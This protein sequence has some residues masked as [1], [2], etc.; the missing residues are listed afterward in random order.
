MIKKATTVFIILFICCSP[1]SDLPNISFKV[2]NLKTFSKIY[3][4]IKY[5][6][7]SDEAFALDWD[8]FSIYAANKILKCETNEAFINTIDSLF[9]PI[10]PSIRFANSNGDS[11]KIENSNNSDVLGEQFWFHKGVGYGMTMENDRYYS[12]R[13]IATPE[14]DSISYR[15]KYGKTANVSIY[16]GQYVAIPLVVYVIKA[17]TIPKSNKKELNYLL[18]NLH[19]YKIDE[20]SLS[21]RLG[22]II[23]TYN[24][25]QHFFPYFD[26]LRLDWENELENALIR[27][28]KDSS[29]K[30][31]L[32]TLRKF[33]SPL[34]DGHITIDAKGVKEGVYTPP[35]FWEWIGDKLIISDVWK[36]DLNLERGDEIIKING[37]SSKEYFDE[38]NSMI[39]AGTLGWLRNISEELSLSGEKG[40]KITIETNS[41]LIEVTRDQEPY[42]HSK[43][44]TPYEKID[45]RIEYINLSVLDMA[46][47]NYLLPELEKSTGL[48]ID[49]R[50]YPN[51]NGQLIGHLMKT[52]DTTKAWMY[53]PEIVYPD[54]QEPKSYSTSNG[55]GFF[56]PRLPYLGDK[57]VVVITNGRAISYSES[58]MG[59]VKGYKLGTIVGQP[60]AG[61]NGNYN[62]FI[63]PGEIRV[64]W[65]GMKVVKHDG[66]QLFGIG[67]L[68]DIYVQ[69]TVRGIKEGRDEFLE[70]AIEIVR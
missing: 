34:N 14:N 48:I 7:P 55:H 44:S 35:F 21:F 10:A 11:M 15:P 69:K 64:K 56:E 49:L 59:Y 67:I 45:E 61:T 4:Y 60:T 52:R 62:R 66:S 31:H 53:F 29:L 46:T 19:N 5:F 20:S 2:Q 12:Q 6:H 23:N 28:F 36:D 30:D 63:L 68:P 8:K 51:D 16:E 27:S 41:E 17:G 26:D 13:I 24:V 50:G 37:I 39:S 9:S 18:T 1:K 65:T 38:I 42:S 25:F 54:Q 70:K 22:N 33:T 58:V 47:F 3:G 43:Y 57:K 40:S 32:I